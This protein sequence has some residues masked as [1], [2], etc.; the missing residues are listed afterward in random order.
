MILDLTEEDIIFLIELCLKCS[1]FKFRDKIYQQKDGIP[2]G[3]PISPVFADLFMESLE[4]TILPNPFI[5]FWKRYVDDTFTIIKGR[6][7]QEILKK[8]N[9]FHYNIKFTTELED[10]GKI[11]FLDVRLNTKPDGT[12][13]HTIHRKLTHTDRYLHFTSF[14]HMSHKI[15][16]VDALAYRAFKICDSMSLDAE[17]SHIRNILR[18]N[19]YP[20]SLI[21][22][23]IEKMKQRVQ[24]NSHPSTVDTTP[25]F[26]LPF[27]GPTTSRL[28]D[29]LR[30][31]T[32]FDFGYTPGIK[33]RHF[34]S[35]HKDTKPKLS[36]GIYRIPCNDCPDN[37]VG[38]TGQRTLEVRIKEHGRDIRMMK[39]TSGVAQ[40]IANNPTHTIN[41]KDAKMI[42]HEA[43]YFARKFKEGL[44]INAEPRPM[45]LND[46][47]QLNPIWTPTL[48]PLL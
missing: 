38:E 39:D 45:N 44:Y 36:C 20:L 3:S 29:Y 41:F 40:H 26:V 10:D 4:D 28:T 22:R 9:S 7:C 21:D 15:S 16:V 24:T 12:F 47:M 8:L 1:Y 27:T 14:H 31:K 23:R 5:H 34:L 42:H 18:G 19:G 35:C 17:L 6:K 33:L 2:M 13:G 46:G 48:I 43:R 30:R 25:R 37:Y 11:N 32:Q